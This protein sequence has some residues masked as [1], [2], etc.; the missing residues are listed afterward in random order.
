MR[1]QRVQRATA[2]KRREGGERGYGDAGRHCGQQVRDGC[3]AGRCNLPCIV[4][5][6]QRDRQP[7]G[8]RRAGIGVPARQIGTRRCRTDTN[9]GACQGLIHPRAGPGRVL[10]TGCVMELSQ[11]LL[12]I[13]PTP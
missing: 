1:S 7:F 5:G 13:V 10:T 6:R 3:M 9:P 8:A 4:A 2:L 11:L 12:I